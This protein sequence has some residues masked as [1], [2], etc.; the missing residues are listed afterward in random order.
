MAHRIEVSLKPGLRDALGLKTVK[1]AREDLSLDIEDIRTAK[2]YLIDAD[3]SEDQLKEAAMGPCSDPVTQVFTIDCPISARLARETG[4]DWHWAIEVGFRPGVTDNEGKTAR[5]ALELLLGRKL[6]PEEGVYTATVYL[7][8]G[9]ITRSEAESLT[10][11]LLANELIQRTIICPFHDLEAAFSRQDSPFYKVPRVLGETRIEILEFDLSAM[12]DQELLRLSRER[13]LVLNLN[14]MKCLQAH[15]QKEEVVSQRQEVGLGGSYTDCELEALAQTWSEH[16]KHKIFNARITYETPDGTEEINSLFD[17]CI[18]GATTAIREKL[19]DEDWCL[20]VF[21]DNAGVVRFNNELNVAFKVETHNSPSALDPY[22]GALTGIVGVNRDPFGTGLGAKLV[23]NTDVFCFGPPDYD[24]PLPEGLLHPK[25]IFEGVRE[26]VEHGGNQ[27]GIPTVNGSILFD[28]R[29]I[30][31]PLVFCGTG[32]VMP[33]EVNGRKAWEKKAKPG[34]AIV[35]CGGRI[36]KDGI[37]GA[38]FSS[39]ELHEGSPATA[40]QIGDPITQKKMTDFLLR[41]RDLGL[42]NSITDNG[43]GGLS[44][45]VGEMAE[46]SGGFEL[47]LDR[48][49]LKYPGLQPWEILV[50][51]AQERMTVAVPPENLEEFLG[52]SEKMGVEST[53]LGTFTDSGK[54]HCLYQ[55]KT[56]AYLDMDFIHNGVPQLELRAVW[57]PPEHKEPSFPEPRDLGAELKR[58]L[59]SFDICSK[60]YVVRQYDH[61]VQGGSV[62]KPLTGAA[63]DGPSDA[64]VLRPD[65]NRFEGLVISHGVCPRYSDIDTYYMVCA[66]VDEAVRNALCVGASFHGMSG[67]DNFC[68]CDPVQSEKTPDGHYKLAQLVR[69]NKALYEICTAYQIPCISGKDSMKNDATI[70]GVKISI[71]PTLL[72]SLIARIP[73]VRLAVTMDVKRPGDLVYVMGTTYPELGASEYFRSRG[74][75]GNSI[76]RVRIREAAEAYRRLADAMAKGVVSSCHDCSDGGLGV[77]LAEK[78]FSGS[79]GM[80]IDLSRVPRQDVDRLDWLLF[81]ESQSRFVL[82]VAPENR[83]ALEGCLSGTTFSLLGQVRAD[84]R[85]NMTFDGRTVVSEEL[86]D[87][88]EAWQKPLRW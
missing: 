58:L 53:V 42:Y 4:M 80:D 32:G 20:S 47:H 27:S 18:R 70:G 74:F 52:L 14:E 86:Q 85:L 48:A 3:I 81:S 71:P 38:T 7:V 22:G 10:S 21:K 66:A 67:L 16:C 56:V 87:L 44:S 79:L 11:G 6:S 43:A 35:M 45:S 46:E 24:Q 19:G 23:F 51:E 49:P 63:N 59:S 37:H 50:S 41:A 84:S 40:V 54:Y 9:N 26:G 78:A 73:D 65:L 75:I 31:K 68:W 5:E 34:D 69:A 62:V 82:T 12:T 36:G 25:R 8:R 55:G 39:E 88:K 1:R 2:A 13:V 77:C 33:M 72:F 30:G 57:K 29:Y 28:E 83:K 17:T 61:E 64:A 60:E 15:L 76:P